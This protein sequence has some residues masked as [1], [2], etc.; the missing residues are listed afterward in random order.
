M[1]NEI[2]QIVAHNAQ[3]SIVKTARSS[4]FFGIIADGTTD[5][6]GQEQFTLYVRWVD[7]SKLTAREAFVGLYNALDSRADTIYK[8]LKDIILLIGLEFQNLRGHCFNEPANISNR[9]SGLQKKNCDAELRS[10]DVH[11]SNHFLDFVLQEASKSCDIINDAL[12]LVK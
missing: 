4:P 5:I 7:R 1:Q 10:L 2:I 6:T 3:R 9:F 11:C 8:G 12:S